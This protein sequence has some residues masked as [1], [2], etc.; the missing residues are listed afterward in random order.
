MLKL[1]TLLLKMMLTLFT[2]LLTM[3]LLM[4]LTMLQKKEERMLLT[5]LVMLLLVELKLPVYLVLQDSKD[6]DQA[7]EDHHCSQRLGRFCRKLPKNYFT[8]NNK[9]RKGEVNNN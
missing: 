1:F 9:I 7:N 3:L 6:L 5:V 2:L 8:D 4:L